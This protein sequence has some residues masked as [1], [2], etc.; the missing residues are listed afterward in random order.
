MQINKDISSLE[1]QAHEIRKNNMSQFEAILT[2]SQKKT[3]KE[4]KQEGRKKYRENHP[5]YSR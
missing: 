1:K 3:L 5:P 4:M 2:P